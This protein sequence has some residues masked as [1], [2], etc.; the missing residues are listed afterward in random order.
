MGSVHVNEI[1]RG[2]RLRDVGERRGSSVGSVGALTVIGAI[3]VD[4]GTSLRG[5]AARARR[6]AGLGTRP[7]TPPVRPDLA[8]LLL[9]QI[10]LLAGRVNKLG[11]LGWG[12]GNPG[13]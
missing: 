13:E 10:C 2:R 12:E 7:P 6:L 8:R 4:P 11:R 1:T 3:R 5:A 9:R